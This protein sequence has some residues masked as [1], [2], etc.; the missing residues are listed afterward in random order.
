MKSIVRFQ[1]EVETPTSRESIMLEALLNLPESRPHNFPG[2]EGF[3]EACQR[4]KAAE[5]AVKDSERSLALCAREIREYVRKNWKP[6][7][8]PNK[9]SVVLNVW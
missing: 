8:I 2:F 4:L 1:Q 5:Q 3:Q 9:T 6:D 7:E